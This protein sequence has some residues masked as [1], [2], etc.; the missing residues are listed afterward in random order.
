MARTGR[1]TA[2]LSGPKPAASHA[3]KTAEAAGATGG[4]ALGKPPTHAGSQYCSADRISLNSGTKPR[5][6]AAQGQHLRDTDQEK[7]VQAPAGNAAPAP[8][9]GEGLHNKYAD[10]IYQHM[11]RT[12][13][14]VAPAV[15]PAPVSTCSYA[16]L[17]MWLVLRTPLPAP[18]S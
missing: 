14:S 5:L 8:V 6:S 9:E 15:P 7:E 1:R 3:P 17:P 13:V 18:F 12:E 11:R 16:P 4:D 10:D 2:L